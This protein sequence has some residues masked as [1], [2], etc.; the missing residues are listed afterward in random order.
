MREGI[1]P[2]LQPVLSGLPPAVEMR[3]TGIIGRTGCPLLLQIQ[4]L[5]QLKVE[6]G[7]GNYSCESFIDLGQTRVSP[8]TA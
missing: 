2:H 5:L 6:K 7:S 3:L 4:V 8:R 1:Q